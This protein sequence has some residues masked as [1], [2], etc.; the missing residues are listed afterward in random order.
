VP[1]SIERDPPPE[2]RRGFWIAAGLL[3]LAGGLL[4][5]VYLWLDDVARGDQGM[6]PV[7]LVEEL[8]GSGFAFPL[9]AALV[10]VARRWPIERGVWRRHLPA[11]VVALL[12]YSALHTTCLA[13]SRAVLFP[14]LGLGEYDYGRMPVPYFMELPND[15]I[16]YAVY[17][18]LLRAVD[19]YHALRQRERR[20]AALERSLA[21]AELESLRLRLQPHFL[22]NAL[23]TISS[24]MYDDPAAADVMIGHLADLLRESLRSAHATEVPLREELRLLESYAALMRAR[25][26][27]GLT[28]A[29]DTEAGLERAAVPPLILQPLV[30]NAVRHGNATRLGRGRVEVRARAEGRALVLTV[31]DDGPGAPADVDPLRSGVGLS[32]TADRLRLLYGTAGALAVQPAAGGGFAVTAR[33]PLRVLPPAPDVGAGGPQRG[34]AVAPAAG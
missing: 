12:V 28:I 4:K 5:A 11:H 8:T 34:A 31:E 32:T 13:L 16:S 6:L 25:F 22:F 9:F 20:E 30:E 33:L 2:S 23:N 15:A 3:F 26:G 18:A 27:D 29:V 7:R 19:Y 17:M 24:T 10:V 14:L 21:R 1:Q